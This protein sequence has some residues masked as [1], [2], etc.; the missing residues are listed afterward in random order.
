MNMEQARG[1]TGVVK[2]WVKVVGAFGLFFSTFFL[3]KNI[4]FRTM[5][6]ARCF[7]QEIIK[8]HLW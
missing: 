4:N 5:T 1:E 2:A 8:A 3:K 6:L 7:F